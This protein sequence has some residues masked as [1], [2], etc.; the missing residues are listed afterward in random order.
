MKRLLSMTEEEI[1]NH[2]DLLINVFDHDHYILLWN[3][4]CENLFGIK[5]EDALG[6][7]LEEIVPYT[8]NSQ[9]MNRLNEALSGESV[10]VEDD[11]MDNSNYYYSQVV[12]PVRNSNGKIIAAVNVVRRIAIIKPEEKSIGLTVFGDKHQ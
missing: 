10:Y 2:P 11:K 5:E 7:K 12:L 8:R 3:K 6:K 4:Q 9:K 1:I